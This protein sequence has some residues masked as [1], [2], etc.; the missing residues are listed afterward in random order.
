MH[1]EI[2]LADGYRISDDPARFDIDVIHGYLSGEAYWSKGRP[3]ALVERVV[4]YALCLGMYAPGGA[5]VGFAKV[6]TDRTIAAH[7]GDV[8]ILP[9]HRGAGRGVALVRAALEH[10]ELATVQRWTLNTRDAHGLYER[11]GFRRTVATDNMMTW[12]RASF[13]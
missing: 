8:F 5:Q 10:P 2:A 11:F 1:L 4:R 12:V 7:L 9:A 6:V 3:R 13:P